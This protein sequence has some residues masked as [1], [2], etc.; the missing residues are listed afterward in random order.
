MALSPKNRLFIM[1]VA[2]P[3][4]H[5]RSAAVERWLPSWCVRSRPQQP[6]LVQSTDHVEEHYQALMPALAPMS[7][8]REHTGARLPSRIRTLFTNFVPPSDDV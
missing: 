2:R 3:V 5:Y 6:A 7:A 1:V 8:A 4:A